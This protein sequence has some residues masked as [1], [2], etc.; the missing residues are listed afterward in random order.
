MKKL[1]IGAAMLAAVIT[2][3]SKKD[4][5][6][7]GSGNPDN[8]TPVPGVTKKDT[9][10]VYK[11]IEFDISPDKDK[12]GVAFSTKEGKVYLRK[13]LPADGSKIDLVFADVDPAMLFFSSPDNKNLTV[14]ITGAT[15]TLF[16]NYPSANELDPAKFDTLSH[17]AALNNLFTAADNG[18]FPMT[19]KGLVLFKNAAGKFGVMKVTAINAERVQV[20]IKTQL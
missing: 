16:R 13:N 12:Y 19:Y 6:N 5:T 9:L 1:F 4:D 18:S 8:N 20:T 3:C 10:A 14:K 2:A 7:T 11:D 17:V 15:T